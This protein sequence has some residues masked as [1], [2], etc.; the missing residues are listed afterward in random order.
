MTAKEEYLPVPTISRDVNVR[1]A[2]TRG[3]GVAMGY[4]FGLQRLLPLSAAAHEVDDFDFVALTDHRGLERC[5]AN[6]HEVVLDGDSP[7]IDRQRGE[8]GRHGYRTVELVRFAVEG[9]GHE[10]RGK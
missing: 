5:P 7:P 6:H 3:S 1:P 9:D 8:Q 10:P 4:V 2:M